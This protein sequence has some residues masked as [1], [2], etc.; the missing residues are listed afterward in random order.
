MSEEYGSDYISLTDDE[1]NEFELE[2]L[3]A[4]EIDGSMY[5]AFVPTD[6]DP[7]GEDDLDIII[8][9]SVDVEGEEMLSTPDTDE[10]LELAYQQFMSRLFDAQEDD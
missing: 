3:D 9:K 5:H 8:L 7:D 4:W 2:L 6:S 10:E 1:G